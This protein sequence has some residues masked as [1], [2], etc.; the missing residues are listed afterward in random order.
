MTITNHAVTG[1]LVAAAINRPILSIPAALLS[2]FAI[3]VIPHW[4]YRFKNQPFKQ[5]AIM[6]DLTLSLT[7]LLFLAVSVHASQRLIIAGGVLGILPDLMWAP[8]ILFN[9]P[10]PTDKTSLLH[11]LRRLHL[12]I[13][14]SETKKGIYV[15]ITWLI[16]TLLLTLRLR[17]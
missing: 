10:S 6:I 3:D 14:W 12:K 16:F 9:K 1:A 4:D 15:E 2:H 13:Q 17:R 5:A 11:L 7:L 8:Y